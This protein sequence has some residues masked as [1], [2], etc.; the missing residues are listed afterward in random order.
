MRPGRYSVVIENR[1]LLQDDV[2]S[3][4]TKFPETMRVFEEL[5]GNVNH[6]F[7]TARR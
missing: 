4:T 5:C 7:Q 1:V 2:I 6:L 3:L